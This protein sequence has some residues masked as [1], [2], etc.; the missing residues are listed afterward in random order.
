MNRRQKLKQLKKQKD[1]MWRV[2]KQTPEMERLYHAYNDIPKN[3][4]CTN[5]AFEHLKAYH[6]LPIDEV[7]DE[8]ILDAYRDWL[9]SDLCKLAK[10]FI[11]YNINREHYI[12]RLEADLYIGIKM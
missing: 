7:I 1:L 8:K 2:I 12:P 6:N 9:V 10:D 4:T 11:H 5:M 3:I